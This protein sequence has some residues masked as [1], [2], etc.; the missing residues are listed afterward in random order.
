MYRERVHIEYLA[1]KLEESGDGGYRFGGGG[2]RHIGIIQHTTFRIVT[3]EVHINKLA[4]IVELISGRFMK[5]L[6][7]LCSK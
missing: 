3:A 1:K 4:E 7:Y 5:K 2:L 6:N